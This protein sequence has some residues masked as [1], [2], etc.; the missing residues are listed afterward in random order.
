MTERT[1]YPDGIPCWVELTTPDTV[2][3]SVFYG[4]LLGWSCEDLSEQTGRYM[5]CSVNGRPVAALT[6]Q[7][8]PSAESGWNV[9]LATSDVEVTAAK[10]EANGGKL[11][12]PPTAEPGFGHYAVAADPTGATFGLWQADPFIGS[13]LHSE[14]GAMCWHEINTV[15]GRAADAFYRALFGYE[16]EQIGDGAGFDYTVWQ[17]DG[18]QVC[19]RLKMTDEWA[20]VAPHWMTYFAVADCDAAASRVPELGGELAHGPFDSAYGRMAVVGDPFRA[21]FTLCRLPDDQQD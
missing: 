17:L 20:G 16:Q 2:A 6:L 13:Q 1:G 14:P 12:T 10:V 21:P 19:G 18:E 9:Y 8:D 7:T 11:L 15:D 5:M 4:D 3:A